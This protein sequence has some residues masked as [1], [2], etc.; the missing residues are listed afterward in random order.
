MEADPEDVVF[1][2]VAAANFRFSPNNLE[3]KAGQKAQ[4]MLTSDGRGHTFT[5]DSLGVDVMVPAGTTQTIEF[6][7]PASASGTIPF[8]C[9]FHSSGG[10]GMVGEL[11]ITRTSSPGDGN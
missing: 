9:R 3:F 2:S 6:K 8:I 7:V 10:K 11:K 1:Y 4:L 5:V